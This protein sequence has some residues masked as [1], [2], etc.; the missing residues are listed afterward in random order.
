MPFSTTNVST[1]GKTLVRFFDARI[2]KKRTPNV[3][4]K[5]TKNIVWPGGQ[6]RCLLRWSH[7]CIE[8]TPNDQIQKMTPSAQLLLYTWMH[9]TL[10][11]KGDRE[12]LPHYHFLGLFSSNGR[13]ILE[14]GI[15]RFPW[16]HSLEFSRGV[17][18]WSAG[19][20]SFSKI[21]RGLTPNCNPPPAWVPPCFAQK[22]SKLVTGIRG[23]T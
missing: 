23:T 2:V 14:T 13:W 21:V 10:L 22:R 17:L 16:Q 9:T 1:Q 3:P 8:V 12:S 20:T 5:S 18:V 19:P 4:I 6:H 11:M 7:A 15:S